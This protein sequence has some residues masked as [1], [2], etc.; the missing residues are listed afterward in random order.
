MINLYDIAYGVG[1]GLS[2]PYW[3]LR[4]SARRKVLGAF[5][6]RMGKVPTRDLSKPAVMIHAV[7]VG[8]VNATR[9]LTRLL[10][11]AR[12]ELQ[13]VI[14]TTTATGAARARELYGNQPDITLIRYPLDFTG[15]VSR[16]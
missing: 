16:V 12:P 10:K 8:E 2:S 4:P 9:E 13:F 3:M 15:A 11:Q 1:V 6:Q 5:A 7:S 14:S